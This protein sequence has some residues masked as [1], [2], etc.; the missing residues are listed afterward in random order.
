MNESEAAK[1]LLYENFPIEHWHSKLRK[2]QRQGDN[3]ADSVVNDVNEV[4]QFMS[5]TDKF[6]F[7]PF[8][9]SSS[10]FTLLDVNGLDAW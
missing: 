6:T 5:V 1:D 4:L 3:K 9:T 7:P 2:S 10:N 8:A